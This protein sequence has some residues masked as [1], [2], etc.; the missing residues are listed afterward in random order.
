MLKRGTNLIKHFIQLIAHTLQLCLAL[1][2]ILCAQRKRCE[3]FQPS[4]QLYL[5]LAE[6]VQ[7]VGSG[8]TRRFYPSSARI[9]ML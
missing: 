2:G 7:L 8:A 9:S 4:R 3:L 1:T 6:D 5:L